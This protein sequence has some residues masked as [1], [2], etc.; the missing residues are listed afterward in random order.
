MNTVRSYKGN[1][2]Y[3][4]ISY[5]HQDT[6]KIHP[7]VAG[8]ADRGFRV[9]Y[10][11]GI[12]PGTEWPEYIAKQISASACCIA[13]LS[14]SSLNSQNCKREI[15]YAVQTSV[16]LLTVYLEEVELS[17]GMALQLSPVQAL[18]AYRYA[19]DEFLRVLSAVPLLDPCRDGS[20]R[21]REASAGTPVPKGDF[22]TRGTA[23]GASSGEAVKGAV[24]SDAGK[25][26][27]G[28]D[29][30]NGKNRQP[31]QGSQPKP[32]SAPPGKRRKTAAIAAGAAAL[33][34]GTAALGWF[35]V[36][37]HSAQNDAVSGRVRVQ[38][39]APDTMSV[40][41]YSDAVGILEDRINVLTAG[42]YEMDVR[43][44]SVSV[45]FPEDIL[46][47]ADMDSVLRDYIARPETLYACN[48]DTREFLPLTDAIESAELLE[49]SVEGADAASIGIEADSYSYIKLTLSSDWL[50]QNPSVA[51]WDDKFAFALDAEAYY[52]NIR[53][54][55]ACPAEDPSAW[56]LISADQQDGLLKLLE[57]NLT[58]KGLADAFSS[59]IVADVR[60]EDPKSSQRPGEY[61][62]MDSELG[63]ASAWI[64]FS[65]SSDSLSEGEMIDSEIG[66][67]K[68]LD[69]L[70]VP[71]A[72]GVAQDGSTAFSA[73]IETGHADQTVLNMISAAAPEAVLSCGGSALRLGAGEILSVS[74]P[75]SSGHITVTLAA[76]SVRKVSGF[77][78]S[79]PDA[80]KESVCLFI[81]SY[82][83]LTGSAAQWSLPELTFDRICYD[84]YSDMGEES[85]WVSHLAESLCSGPA[86]PCLFIPT[87]E[88]VSAEDSAARSAVLPA[89]YASLYDRT[90]ADIT[91]QYPD[92]EVS[93][94]D[95]LYDGGLTLD[96]NLHFTDTAHAATAA[97][98]ILEICDLIDFEHSWFASV[99]FIAAEGASGTDDVTVVYRKSYRSG[100]HDA[101]ILVQSVTP[102]IVIPD[103]ALT[104]EA[105]EFRSLL[106]SQV[107]AETEADRLSFEQLGVRKDG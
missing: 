8:L 74:E 50:E 13:F 78:L 91:K 27:S 1:E 7:I 34:I 4:F 61:Q 101:N 62:I 96:V 35:L 23:Q 64:T 106:E 59:R 85:A 43:E 102:S 68:R 83:V 70:Q 82:P 33:V 10:D 17:P 2:P 41:D 19:P 16:P 86:L 36:P 31:G 107:T 105:D 32:P 53:I 51:S 54:F 67:K 40:R 29:G 45:S 38:L 76:D 56:Y 72:F 42:E 49:G 5:S 3:I 52:P 65:A 77:L 22:G 60:W 21:S 39:T 71:Y 95:S 90:K 100:A 15:N 48:T 81:D 97:R 104:G 25:V 26:P 103:G 92:A 46:G 9:W 12:E 66:L 58:H 79:L 84:G 24:S 6:E 98:E 20:R 44:D 73:R 14:E 93:F 88:E 94:S 30:K 63:A 28:S 18:F 80:D 11:E 99:C 37:R 87:V 89:L 57:Y 47:D 69:A 75:D 55:Y